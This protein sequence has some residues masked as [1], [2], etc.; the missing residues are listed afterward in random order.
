MRVNADGTLDNNFGDKGLALTSIAQSL[1]IGRAMILFS[2]GRILVTGDVYN[3]I[4]DNNRSFIACYKPDGSLDEDFGDKGIVIIELND[5]M[6]I[7]AIAATSENKIILGGNYKTY[8]K[9]ILLRY[10]NDGTI[11]KTFGTNGLAEMSFPKNISTPTIKDIAITSDNKIVTAGYG[12]FISNNSAIMVSRFS[13][14]GVPDSSFGTNAYTITKYDGGNAYANSIAVQPNGKIIAGGYFNFKETGLFTIARYTASGLIDSSF[15]SNGIVNTFFY[16]DDIGSSVV[17]QKDGKI[18]LSGYGVIDSL[19]EY[20]PR[21]CIARYNNDDKSKQQIIITKIRR[22]LQHHNGFTWDA[23]SSIRN[24][25]VQRSYDGIHFSSIARVN[26]SNNSNYTYQDQTPLKGT[27]YYRL[28]TA[29]ISGAVAYSNVIA[30]S[31]ENVLNVFL[32]PNP[33]TNNLQ[34]QGLPSNQNINV[35][36]V[37]V[38]GN[39]AISQQLKANSLPNYNLNIAALKTGNYLLKIEVN[40]NVVYKR[41]CKGITLNNI[42][43][44]L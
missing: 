7:N 28:Q 42:I 27:N 16:G 10:N 5:P 1:T 17:L 6:D 43:E 15:G 8:Y 29:S 33:A 26:S 20:K 18:V 24:Y 36:V 3:G 30:V 44:F 31:D 25:V 32:S 14:I 12:Y 23:N 41:I 2:D 38:T 11:D 9:N 13:E 19:A 4:N 37:D 39:I 34:I 40:N 21:V 22:W 35:T